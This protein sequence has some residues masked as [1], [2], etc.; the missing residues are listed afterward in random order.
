MQK[1]SNAVSYNGLVPYPII[2]TRVGAHL[3]DTLCLVGIQHLL[4]AGQLHGL[5]IPYV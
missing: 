5:T 4:G 1:R 2:V 3:R